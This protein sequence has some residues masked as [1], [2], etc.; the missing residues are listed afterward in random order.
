MFEMLFHGLYDCHRCRSMFAIGGMISEG[1]PR[2]GSEGRGEECPPPTKGTYVKLTSRAIMELCHK[3]SR[4]SL[5]PTFESKYVYF[6]DF[7][8]SSPKILG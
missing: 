7:C 1:I 4:K 3:M 8:F 5:V 2:R 6:L